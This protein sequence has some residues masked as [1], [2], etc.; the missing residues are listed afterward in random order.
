[1]MKAKRMELSAAGFCGYLTEP[2]K[3]A[4]HG[5]VVILGE[6]C[7]TQLL[8]EKLFFSDA[9]RMLKKSSRL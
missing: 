2:D 5:I 7:G 6:K 4:G 9:M 3:S 1:M 8:E